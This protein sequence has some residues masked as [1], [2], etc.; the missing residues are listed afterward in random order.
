MRR[1]TLLGAGLIT[2]G[3]AALAAIL[4][5]RGGGAAPAPRPAVSTP[6]LDPKAPRSW[7]PRVKERK[8]RLA[9]IAR[10]LIDVATNERRSDEDRRKA[11]FALAEID[12]PE[13]IDYLLKAVALKIPPARRTDDRHEDFPCR[14][15]LRANKNWNVVR[16]ILDDIDNP[17]LK[18][19]LEGYA[20]VLEGVLG[21]G[22]AR[23]LLN[24]DLAHGPTLHEAV[25]KA[26]LRVMLDSLR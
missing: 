26:N 13:S 23:S 18:A 7:A 6:I 2:A 16:A 11:I 25:R 24:D 8:D 9:V 20:A 19:E 10:K 5:T 22:R 15:A 17:K 14:A 1:A 4:L 21:L 12:C 3:L